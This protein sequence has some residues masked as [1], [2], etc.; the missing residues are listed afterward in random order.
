MTNEMMRPCTLWGRTFD[1]V[2]VYKI[3][4][5]V[6][7]FRKIELVAVEVRDVENDS[8]FFVDKAISSSASE[9]D[10][11]FEAITTIADA[12]N[13]PVLATEE[14]LAGLPKDAKLMTETHF[15]DFDID[16]DDPDGVDNAEPYWGYYEPE[17]VDHYENF[18][19]TSVFG[20][21]IKSNGC[22]KT[23]EYLRQ[24]TLDGK[25]KETKDA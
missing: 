21:R 10:L 20:E 8:W 5:T 14:V 25:R 18:T 9:S 11:F 22:S 3:R 4:P 1:A 16:P 6:E 24:F 7:L 2:D 13:A 19:F 15:S 23:A 12:L 17:F